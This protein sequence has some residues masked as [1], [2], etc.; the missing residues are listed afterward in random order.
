VLR[1]PGRLRL[2]RSCAV[3]RA[4]VQ[5]ASM[6]SVRAVMLLRRCVCGCAAAI[7]SLGVD[8]DESDVRAFLRE[9]PRGGQTD[10]ARGTRHD[11]DV[12]AEASPR[13]RL[14]IADGQVPRFPR[15]RVG[16]RT[17]ERSRQPVKRARSSV[18]RG[19]ARL[20]RALRRLRWMS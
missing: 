4:Y 1:L 10:A 8:I 7:E 11:G 15:L 18:E 13:L 2:V 14:G 16:S 12:S 19:T 17:T 20:R 3:W 6:I 5:V 9:S